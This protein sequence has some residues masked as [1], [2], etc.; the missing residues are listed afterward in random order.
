MA[1]LEPID[2][3][4]LQQ[5]IGAGKEEVIYLSNDANGQNPVKGIVGDRGTPYAGRV[6]YFGDKFQRTRDNGS[7]T[8]DYNYAFRA[9]GGGGRRKSKRSRKHRKSRRAKK[10]RRHRR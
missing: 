10:T 5:V 8:D 2:Y 7:G 1:G 3:K 9:A 4:Y 6:I